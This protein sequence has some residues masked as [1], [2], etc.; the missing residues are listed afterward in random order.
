MLRS[1][2]KLHWT[3]WTMTL[4]ALMT[5]FLV[6][7]GGAAEQPAA[8]AQQQ[9]ATKVP[10]AIPKQGI[11]NTPAPQEK[12]A[13]A[14][15]KP[16][17]KTD[18]TAKAA[19]KAASAKQAGAK[20]EQPTPAAVAA[21]GHEDITSA[22]DTFKFVTA[23][24][25]DTV[26]GAHVL[27]S[28]S[29]AETVCD[30]I[31]SDP[32]TWV[33][34]E[35]FEI[36][37]LQG[38]EDWEQLDPKTWR[39]KLRDGVT[40]HNGTEWNADHAAFWISYAGDDET[41]GHG[42]GNDYTFH[43]SFTG[44]AIDPL[45]LDIHCKDACPILPRTTIFTKF[46]DKDWFQNASEDEI[47]TQGPGLGPYKIINW[48]RE[49]RI[50]LEAY[51]N[52]KP[53]PKAV[54]GRA[55]IIQ[56]VIQFWRNEDLVRASMIAAGEADLTEISLDDIDKVPKY[57]VT[58]N[59]EAI[60]YPIDTIYHPELSKFEVRMAL[61]LGLDC[62]TLVEQLYNNLF[63][64]YGNIAQRGTVGINESN[65]SYL[66]YDPE[67]AKR[68]LEVANYD[69]ANEI[70]LT[71]GVADFPKSIEYAEAAVNYWEEI[72]MNVKLNVADIAVR[73]T[74]GRSNCAYGRTRSEIDSA[75]GKD[76]K[77]KCRNLGPSTAGGASAATSG[78]T[79]T[80]TS[81]ESLDFS[82]QALLR[83]WCYYVGRICESD[84]TEKIDIAVATPTGPLRTERLA[85]IAQ[86]AHDHAH[87]VFHFINVVVYAMDADLEWEPYYAPRLRANTVYFTK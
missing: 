61:N 64:C 36:V 59:N 27:C 69:P 6:A 79:T 7:C 16:E 81:T 1:T 26:G 73:R 55:P 82:R 28:G 86:H 66:G 75:P 23:V 47:H 60:N 70:V 62:E 33:D 71:I 58:T 53:N 39:F 84:L 38:F 5:L 15:A 14:T 74:I 44:E 80:R 17:A 37:P 19:Q 12:M 30:D 8:P 18:T 43:G 46:L 77:E 41:R 51:E 24:E 31:S 72:G 65:S 35:T 34:N 57:K 52:Y 2:H 42:F 21:P 40:F 3:A 78:L 20:K 56:H 11:A 45:T 85:E 10:D 67:E 29:F 63:T 50:V 22:R 4:V 83:N 48:E 25:P 13:E 54:D 49:Q 87:F 68:L 76:L 9:E 32:L